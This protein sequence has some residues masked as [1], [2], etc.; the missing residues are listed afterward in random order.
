MAGLFRWYMKVLNK[1]PLVTQA[2]SAGILMGMG[3]TIAQV[4]VEK[5]GLKNYDVP[6]TTKF[7]LFGTIVLGP[8]LKA[9]YVLLDK[10]YKGQGALTTIKKVAT[11]QTILAPVLLCVVL[12]SI[13]F[14]NTYSVQAV[15]A[16]LKQDYKEVLITN[17]KV[18]PAA[19]L[20]NFYFVPLQL[21]VVYVQ[22]I[23]LFWNTYIAYIGNRE[24]PEENPEK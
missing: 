13:N 9:W 19:Q 15:K 3:D 2:L 8:G 16:K 21:R 1:R 4:A 23:A 7:F 20:I 12:G 17:Y 22:V 14:W 6:R 11:D 10:L 24:V 18:W 5:K